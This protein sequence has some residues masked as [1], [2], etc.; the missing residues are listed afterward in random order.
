MMFVHLLLECVEGWECENSKMLF[1][2]AYPLT[3]RVEW[4]FCLLLVAVSML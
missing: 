1:G 3:E 2:I 4:V